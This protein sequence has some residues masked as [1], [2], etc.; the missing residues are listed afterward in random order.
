MSA[1]TTWQFAPV[2]TALLVLLAVGYLCGVVS[3]RR[4]HPAGPW[5]ANRTAAFLLGLAATAVA[6]QSSLGVYDDVLFSV[7]MACTPGSKRVVRS[8]AATALTWPPFTVTLYAAVGAATHLTPLMDLVLENP[9]VHDA[10]HVLYLVAGYLFFLP[11]IGRAAARAALSA[12][13]VLPATA[14]HGTRHGRGGWY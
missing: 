14:G 12:R 5:P 6:T 13:Q 1:L 11:V 3:V 10:E 7:H 8:P 9:A 2:V 4:G